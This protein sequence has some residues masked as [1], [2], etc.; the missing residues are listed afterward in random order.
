MADKE[1]YGLENGARGARADED[2]LSSEIEK[3]REKTFDDEFR[4]LVSRV[5]SHRPGD[6]DLQADAERD[7]IR[8]FQELFY[9]ASGLFHL[10]D[11]YPGADHL[12]YELATLEDSLALHI[13][14]EMDTLG[15]RHFAILTYD[16]QKKSFACRMN[17][18]TQINR[19]N[20]VMDI[21]EPL[22]RRI[23]KS[24]RGI[25][26]D[27][28]AV[29]RDPFLKKRFVPEETGAVSGAIF[30]I[31][32][33]FLEDDL[34]RDAGT[35]AP[36]RPPVIP[37]VLMVLTDAPPDDSPRNDLFTRL[38][39]RLSFALALYK[40]LLYPKVAEYGTGGLAGAVDVLEYYFTLYFQVLEG[41]VIF[42]RY[43]QRSNP[44]SDFMFT[45]L[46]RKIVDAFPGRAAVVSLDK[47]TLF[48]FCRQRD[49]KALKKLILDYS[50]DAGGPFTCDSWEHRQAFTFNSLLAEYLK[51]RI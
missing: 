16:F 43:S 17:H 27:A 39:R 21:D 7:L 29:E 46:A 34:F 49:F 38:K 31:S 8:R 28:A 15:L 47:F 22:F 2:S 41:G 50:A 42:V 14:G 51:S 25:Y 18:I 40:N 35:D 32:L 23:M 6:R 1:Q 24:R 4:D 26:V 30:F 44:E 33:G 12:D 13:Y 10:E 11:A 20:L 19:D 36:A 5:T 9:R 37:T 3:I 48:A 45:Y